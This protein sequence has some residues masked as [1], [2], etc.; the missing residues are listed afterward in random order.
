MS[1]VAA[2]IKPTI[3]TR[4]VANIL[5]GYQRQGGDVNQLLGSVGLKPLADMAQARISVAKFYELT[6]AI[7]Q[8]LQ[9]EM[10]GFLSS[11][12]P[13]GSIEKLMG[14]CIKLPTLG[15]VLAG[16]SD[17]Y[18]LFNQGQGVLA[19]EYCN[20]HTRLT[21]TPA[22]EFQRRSPYFNQRLL[23]TSYKTCCWLGKTRFHLKEVC[24]SFPA[25][26][27]KQ[28]FNF[29]FDCSQIKEGEQS[30]IEFATDVRSLPLLRGVDEVTDLTKNYS[31]YTLLWPSFDSLSARIRDLI[32]N[33]ITAGFPSFDKVAEGLGVSPQTL[34]RR[35]QESGISYQAIKDAIRR[36]A[37][38]ALL[39]NRNYSIKQIAYQVGF[40]ESGS[41]SKA[42]KG[43]L[44]VSPSEYREGI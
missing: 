35:L 25:M 26:Q 5:A 44:G 31:F 16:Y 13:L 1:L 14:I 20:G 12:V 28:E 2:S 7:E 41:F 18:S 21:V 37:A 3:K 43:W 36:D 29:V 33:D 22:N 8:A 17:F 4:F 27:D 6:L 42:F 24:F 11:P 19:A 10:L 32:G 15:D 23:L 40:K 38:I 34:S 39:A 9:D 30:Y